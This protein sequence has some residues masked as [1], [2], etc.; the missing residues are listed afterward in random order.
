[1]TRALFCSERVYKQLGILEPVL[2]LPSS[3][4]CCSLLALLLQSSAAVGFC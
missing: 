2:A 1:M 4:A 3:E